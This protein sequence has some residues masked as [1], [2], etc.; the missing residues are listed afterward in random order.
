MHLDFVLVRV[1]GQGFASIEQC[2]NDNACLKPCFCV[3]S[4]VLF[5]HFSCKLSQ[6]WRHFFNV[7]VPFDVQW[8]GVSYCWPSPKVLDLVDN[9]EDFVVD[10]GKGVPWL[11]TWVPLGWKSGWINYKHLRACPFVYRT[12]LGVRCSGSRIQHRVS[13]RFFV[14]DRRREMLNR[15]SCM[16]FEELKSPRV[17]SLSCLL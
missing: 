6:C 15:R 8:E 7:F 2:A 10:S 11:I 13:L 9:V 3:Y 17:M 12:L 1:C 16:S 14:L 5:P 4:Q